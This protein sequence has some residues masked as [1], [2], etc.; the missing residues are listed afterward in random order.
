M[1][2]SDGMDL[3]SRVLGTLF[4]ADYILKELS[5]GVSVRSR[6]PYE[7]EP[8]SEENIYRCVVRPTNQNFLQP[9]IKISFAVH[10]CI[11][12]MDEKLI[13]D[14]KPIPDRGNSGS[15]VS[16]LWIQADSLDLEKKTVR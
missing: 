9:I 5:V 16:R 7:I 15:R 11:S 8:A 10:V 4:H 2:H 12:G 6:A 14:I 13:D 1:R 3:S